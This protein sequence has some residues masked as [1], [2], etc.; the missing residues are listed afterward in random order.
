MLRLLQCILVVTL[1]LV[2]SMLGLASANQTIIWY[3]PH[4]DDETIGMADSIHQS[5]RAGNANYFIYFSH[6]SNS[7]VRHSLRGPGGEKY[8]LDVEEFGQA[9]VRET[10]AALEILGVDLSQ[11]I[12]F[13]FPDGSIPQEPVEKTMELFAQLYPGSIHR[14]V[15]SL[16]PHEDHQTLARALAAVADR[17]EFVMYPEYFHVYIYRRAQLPDSLEKRPVQYGQVKEAALAQLSLWDPENGRYAIAAQ[18]TPDLIEGARRSSFE[19]VDAPMN[20]RRPHT[21]AML[22]PGVTLSTRDIGVFLRINDRL[23]LDGLFEY[24]TQ[25]LATEISYRLRDQI[26]LVQ[27]VVGV[28]Y[29]FEHSK[30]YITSKV[31][32]V[33]NYFLRIRHLFPNETNIAIGVTTRL[34]R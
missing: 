13:D 5:V 4:P 33:G 9:R 8:S 26:P 21:T 27:L 31:E 10:L 6:G 18:S 12:F 30:P 32:I 20:Q 28:G 29:H 16:D 15:S 11:V 17:E 19:Y 7:L 14:T 22:T 23:S 24:K 1:V 34:G 25:G 2:L 3:L